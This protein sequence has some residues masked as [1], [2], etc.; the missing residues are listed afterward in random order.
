VE[1]VG[2]AFSALRVVT[3]LTQRENGS[4]H[5]QVTISHK[6]LFTIVVS[7]GAKMSK[8][9]FKAVLFCTKEVF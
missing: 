3:D 5:V 9:F 4:D 1:S 6:Y 2:I 7:A 8:Q